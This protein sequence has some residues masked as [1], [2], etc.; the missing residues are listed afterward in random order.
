MARKTPESLYVDGVHSVPSAGLFS[1]TNTNASVARMCEAL[2]EFGFEPTE[3]I[4]DKFTTLS[5][6]YWAKKVFAD[7]A[8]S[9]SLRS[10]LAKTARAAAKLADRLDSAAPAARGLI[11]RALG[12]AGSQRPPQPELLSELVDALRRVSM[13]NAPP[14]QRRGALRKT[15]HV[16]YAVHSLALVWMSVSQAEFVNSLDTAQGVHGEQEFVSRPA[17]FVQR[18]GKALDPALGLQPIRASLK[19]GAVKRY[20]DL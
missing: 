12:P 15:H 1:H 9:A 6:N 11:F 4:K 2:A 16:D 19:R 3:I 8:T 10:E 14:S 20:A 17:L 13:A 7:R 18:V 5:N